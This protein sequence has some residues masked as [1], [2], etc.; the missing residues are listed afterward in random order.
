MAERKSGEF[1]ME[2]EWIKAI[3]TRYRKGARY[4]GLGYL[5]DDTE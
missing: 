5:D 3:N 1:R 2:V 4:S